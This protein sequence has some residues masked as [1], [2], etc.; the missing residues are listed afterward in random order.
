MSHRAAGDRDGLYGDFT[1]GDDA[2]AG[3]GAHPS[4]HAAGL[5]SDWEED[6]ER[7]WDVMRSLDLARAMPGVDTRRVIVTGLS[8]G[9][10]V[11]SYAG[12]LDPRVNSVVVAGFTPDL[13]VISYRA[14][15]P[16]W[17]WTHADVREYLGVSVL[18]ALVAPRLLVVETGINDSTFSSFRAPFASD[19]QVLRRSR[20]AWGDRAY[21]L[22]HFL[23]DGAHV[24]RTGDPS[25][26]LTAARGISI[27]VQV[28]P[29]SNGSVAW[30]TDPS[31]QLAPMTVFE[32]TTGA[33][34]R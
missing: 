7:A 27:P 32:L 14:N 8:M 17:R 11:A 3:N 22:V 33:F 21:R 20:A 25:L 28:A 19:K 23:H 16:C 29:A 26:D 15:H 31:T 2:A 13:G 12:A 4:I 6:G 30:Q 5:D 24:Y 10:E 9:G 18:H 1:A 34:G